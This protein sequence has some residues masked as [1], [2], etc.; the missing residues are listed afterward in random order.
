MASLVD[1]FAEAVERHPD[2]VAIV[3]G[4]GRQTSFRALQTRA[5]RMAVKWHGKGIEPGDRVL[6]AMPVNADLYAS[7][8]ALWSLGATVVLPEPAM[9]L[10]RGDADLKILVQRIEQRRVV[11]G[12]RFQG[13]AAQIGEH[14]HRLHAGEFA[15]PDR[16]GHNRGRRPLA[17]IGLQQR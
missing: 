15:A 16:A 13:E 1:H 4:K 2:R 12:C 9:G 14:H 11:P 5:R 3:D 17:Q 10:N 8:A 6:L 7:L